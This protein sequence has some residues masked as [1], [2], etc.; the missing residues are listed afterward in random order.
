MDLATAICR[1]SPTFFKTNHYDAEIALRMVREPSSLLR[2]LLGGSNVVVAG[3]LVGA[4]TFIGQTKMAAQIKQAMELAGNTVRVSNPFENP[5]PVL[6]GRPRIT[7]PHAARI[8]A[9]WSGMRSQVLDAFDQVT[10]RK[11]DTAAYLAEMDERYVAD[12]YNSLSIEG[13][14]V[15]PD[16]IERV[17]TNDWNP[18]ESADKQELS[19]LAARGYY[20]AFQA[21]RQSIT[22]ILSGEPS[23]EVIDSDFQQWY[24]EMFS[25][26]VRAGLLQAEQ[27]AGYRNIPVYLRGS[28]HVP[29]ASDAVADC[30]DAFRDLMAAETEAIVR[31]V[32]GHYVFVYVHPYPDGNGRIGR[33]IM[34]A[35]LSAGG[36]PWTVIRQSHRDEY[37]AALEE[38][39]ISQSLRPFAEFV[40]QEMLAP[41]DNEKTDETGSLT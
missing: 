31:A 5:E 14:R 13:Y 3:R 25:P 9:L 6:R 22:R 7:S 18:D 12:A 35:A 2:I 40:L 36:Y 41:V 20:Q 32:L 37:L 11:I 17:R 34:N 26:S 4:Y 30:M 16:L 24:G 1:L 27:L 33:F 19:A 21:V 28:R 8:Q 15:T 29:P 38:A 10:P 23:A 39:T